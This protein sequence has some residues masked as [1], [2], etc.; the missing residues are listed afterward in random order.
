MF[1]LINIRELLESEN[2]LECTS[3]LLNELNDEDQTNSL[4]ESSSC[5]P[6]NCKLEPEN[7]FMKRCPKKTNKNLNTSAEV[8][9]L[10]FYRKEFKVFLDVLTLAIDSHF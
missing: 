5:F 4:L 2:F 6:K 9:F 8:N 3:K 10:I 7:D 1:K